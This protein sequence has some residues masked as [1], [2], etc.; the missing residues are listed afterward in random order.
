MMIDDW[1]SAF[2]ELEK[3]IDLQ[4]EISESRMN[5]EGGPRRYSSTNVNI[6]NACELHILDF[7]SKKVAE[8]KKE[9][10]MNLNENS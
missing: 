10:L 6:R 8:I 7:I 3:F 1:K 9:L 4:K 2:G 5:S